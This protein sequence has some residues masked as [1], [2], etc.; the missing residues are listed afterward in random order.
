[1]V[2]IWFWQRIATP[3]MAFLAEALA[4]RGLSVVYVANESM[5]VDRAQQGW[6]APELKNVSL[7]I[8]EDVKAISRLVA[9]AP[10]DA[11]HLCQGLRG[12]GLVRIAQGL[13]NRRGIRQW[14]IMEAIEDVGFTGILKRLIYSRLIK[15]RKNSLFGFLAIGRETA[16]WLITLGAEPAQVFPFAYFLARPKVIPSQE[17]ELDRLF[18]FIFV[19]NLIPRKRLGLLLVALSQID[20][21]NF[22]L[23]V[24]GGGPLEGELRYKADQLLPGKVKWRGVLPMNLVPQE[25]AA[26]DCLVLPSRHDGWGA[27]VSEALIVGTSVICSDTCGSAGVV[28]ASGVGAVFKS[29]SVDDLHK[30]LLGQLKQRVVRAGREKLTAWSTALSAEAG[31]EYLIAILNYSAGETARPQPPWRNLTSRP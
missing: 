23:V 24:V 26:A 30:K 4:Q 9:V 28:E 16:D 7:I 2:R 22:E 18:R 15:T 25:I 19:G 13:L 21:L 20:D 14:V 12:N 1:V 17:V 6:L 8:A 31:A 3:H 11:I 5:S 27:V 29:G 10:S